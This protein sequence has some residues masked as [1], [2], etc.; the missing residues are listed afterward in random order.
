MRLTSGTKLMNW[1]KK[2]GSSKFDPKCTAC[3]EV[4]T[5]GTVYL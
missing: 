1:A 5:A 3:E 2:K 4:L